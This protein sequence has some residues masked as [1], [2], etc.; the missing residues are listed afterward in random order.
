[1]T[2][3]Q[4]FFWSWQIENSFAANLD[5]QKS[6]SSCFLHLGFSFVEN[7]DASDFIY[8]LKIHSS[9]MTSPEICSCAGR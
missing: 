7:Q 8:I 9:Q 4:K 5:E 3:I 2:G 1:M 6:R